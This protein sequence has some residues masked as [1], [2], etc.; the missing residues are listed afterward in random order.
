MRTSGIER[1]RESDAESLCQIEPGAAQVCHLNPLLESP[2]MRPVE[3]A[4]ALRRASREKMAGWPVIFS[5]GSRQRKELAAPRA[6]PLSTNAQSSR[7]LWPMSDDMPDRSRDDEF[8]TKLNPEQYAVTR[9]C[10]TERAFSGAYWDEK[11]GG[12]YRCICCDTELFSSDDKYDSGSG[13]PS[14]TQPVE[15][16]T[17]K[18]LVDISHGMRRVEVRCANCDAHL[19][20]K[21]PDGPAPTGERYCINS[22]SLDFKP[23]SK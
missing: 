9:E 11:R 21:F 6:R 22:A 8:R 5:K 18:E 19:G 16:K 10:G 15:A 13:W 1:L 20:H 4:A 12:I 3:R 17:M 14:Y 7:M 2:K 23:T